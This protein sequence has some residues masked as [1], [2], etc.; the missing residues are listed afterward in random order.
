MVAAV[1]SMAWTGQVP[2]HG[3]G[4]EVNGNLTPYEMMVAAGLDWTVSKRQAR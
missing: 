4:V 3:E 1:E 2:W